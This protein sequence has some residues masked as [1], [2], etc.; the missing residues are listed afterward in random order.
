M[1]VSNRNKITGISRR[2]SSNQ[3]RLHE[4]L[5]KIVNSHIQNDFLKPVAAHT[6]EAFEEI[7]KIVRDSKNID[8]ILDSGCGTGDSTLLLGQQCPN[9][10]VIGLDKSPIKLQKTR[11]KQPRNNVLFVRAEQF[12]FWRL[13]ARSKW[14]VRQH[15]MLYPNPWPKKAH[16]KRRIYGHPAFVELPKISKNIVVRSNW[17]I[18]VLEFCVAWTLLTREK[19]YVEQFVPRQYASLFEK[20]FHESGHELYQ[21]V[22]AKEQRWI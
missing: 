22:T 2:V 7:D 3:K 10:L 1:I 16:I 9:H 6:Q 17:E 21:L 20:K 11:I 4:E 13:V 12:D 8:I 14:N 15:Y 19:C 18:Y 5:E